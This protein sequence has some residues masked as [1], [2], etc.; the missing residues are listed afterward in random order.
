MTV[1]FWEGIIQFS[2]LIQQ[3][4]EKIY[5]IGENVFIQK[6]EIIITTLHH[7]SAKLKLVITIKKVPEFYTYFLRNSVTEKS[8]IE[9]SVVTERFAK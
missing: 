3:H 7:N 1:V 9:F 6:L 2:Q 8:L 5:L 4:K